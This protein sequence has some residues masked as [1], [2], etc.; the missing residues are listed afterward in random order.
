[1]RRAVEHGPRRLGRLAP[2]AR[3]V[4]EA[5]AV[6]GLFF[7]FEVVRRIGPLDGLRS[8]ALDADGPRLTLVTCYPLD[9]SRPGGSL[10]YVVHA[11]G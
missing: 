1:M 9:A 6:L 4:L 10:R 7:G 5:G 8:L 2:V 3:Q 11:L